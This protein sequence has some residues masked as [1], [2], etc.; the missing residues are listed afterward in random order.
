M[1][2][3]TGTEG[4]LLWNGNWVSFLDTILQMSVLHHPGRSLRLPTRIKAL[5]INPFEHDAFVEK[6]K[7]EKHGKS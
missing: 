3:T 4:K 6:A 7:D 1:F 5:R 2:A